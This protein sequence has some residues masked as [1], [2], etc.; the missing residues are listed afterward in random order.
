MITNRK[1][2]ERGQ[3]ESEMLLAMAKDVLSQAAAEARSVPEGENHVTVFMRTTFE[4]LGTK[5]ELRSAI[6]ITS[7]LLYSQALPLITSAFERQAHLFGG[8]LTL[9][10]ERLF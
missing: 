4:V 1:N 9:D 5:M 3:S 10:E 2:I 6:P 7:L 8:S